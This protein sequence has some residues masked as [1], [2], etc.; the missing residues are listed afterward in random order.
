MTLPIQDPALGAEGL[1]VPPRRHG[2]LRSV[3]RERKAAVIGLAI[4]VFFILLSVI[5]P[6]ISPYSATAQTCAVYAPPS[7]RHWLGCDDGGIDMLSELMQGGRI[8]LVV[9]FAATVVAMVIGGGVG[10]V[11]GYFSGW[12]D[13]A[14]MRIT[15]YLLV[16]PDLVFALVTGGFL[17]YDYTARANWREAA[18]H[19]EQVAK[20]AEINRNTA[21][22]MERNALAK[23]HKVQSD[24]DSHLIEAVAEMKR[25][26]LEPPIFRSANL[27]GGDE[28][29]AKLLE[30]YRN[31]VKD[32]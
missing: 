27:P 7:S 12:T 22:Q 23:L 32:L 28:F 14:L 31:R 25:R 29:N 18:E 30:R 5:A 11:S 15:D 4:I 1:G 20:V 6:Y 26:G 24:L 13:T 16:I 2:F 9:G 21:I 10:I 17:V 3:L 19:N 8:S